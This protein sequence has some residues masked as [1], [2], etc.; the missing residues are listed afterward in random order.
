MSFLRV[1]YHQRKLGDGSDLLY[2]GG[3][4]QPPA[5]YARS[6]ERDYFLSRKDLNDP[7]T[8]VGGIQID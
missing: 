3:K 5:R 1:E 6:I 7:P 2:Q 8:A 4:L